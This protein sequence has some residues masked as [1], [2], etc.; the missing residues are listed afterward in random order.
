MRE[1]DAVQREPLIKNEDFSEQNRTWRL[2]FLSAVCLVSL[3]FIISRLFILQVVKGPFYKVV[4]D[5]NRI[6]ASVIRAYRGVIKDRNGR[7]LAQ[8]F[9]SFSIKVYK[10]SESFAAILK[11]LSLYIIDTSSPKDAGDFVVFTNVDR[12]T[13]LKVE[14]AFFDFKDIIVEADPQ[15]RYLYPHEFAHILG[16]VSSISEE[17]LEQK[18]YLGYT[19]TDKV[20]VS[21][22][23]KFY[24]T[25]LHGKHGSALYEYDAHGNVLREVSKINPVDGKDLI[26]SLDL[27][28]QRK[29]YESLK[30]AVEGGASTG[31]V[32][33]AQDPK[34][35]QILAL[36]SFPSFDPNL[37]SG[38]SGSRKD[39]ESLVSD[40]RLP[41][42]N[43]ALLGQY[44]PG[45]IFKVVTASALLEEGVVTKNTL[46]EAP[47]AINVG[48]F[49]YRDWNPGG[50]GAVNIVRAIAESADT[51]FYKAVG[52]YSDFNKSLGPE[53][54]ALW[55]KKFGFGSESGIEFGF[56]EKGTIPDPAWK[57]EVKGEAWYIG[58]SYITAI[59]QG[60]VLAT[61]I[62]INQ[63]MSVIA[64]GGYLLRPT[65]VSNS[66]EIAG[67]IES[68]ESAGPVIG[69]SHKVLPDRPVLSGTP[70]AAATRSVNLSNEKA[71]GT[72]SASMSSTSA[73]R[74]VESPDEKIISNGTLQIVKEGLKE[75]CEPGGTGYVFFDFPVKHPGVKVACKTGTSEFGEKNA[76]GQYQKTHAW[77]TVFAPLDNPEIVLT[78]LLEGGGGG[79]QDASPVAREILDWW[80]GELKK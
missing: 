15:R 29:S 8:N 66:S 17:D 27:D 24:D 50:H 19:N 57:K 55:A 35:S 61:P 71:L 31:G 4:S 38:E 60:N 14:P 43:R 16:Y 36:V 40:I 56:E 67:L 39:Y 69:S 41:L 28:L 59:G 9:P 51:F 13:S 54:L 47:G 45:S 64:N 78:V 26:L 30:K 32:V 44:P 6:R 75:A 34:T 80:F 62:Q 68:I 7:I 1:L 37:F 3:V 58:D 53:K 74:L 77:F 12:D 76:Q 73:T 23:E 46:I 25:L 22:I 18:K 48:N 52:G 70:S 72:A 5:E 65:V 79:A 42:F 63:M 10:K 11:K 33:I 2:V 20:G 21:G 49:V